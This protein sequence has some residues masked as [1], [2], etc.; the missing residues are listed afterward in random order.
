MP[1]RVGFILAMEEGKM[2]HDTWKEKV[3]AVM[4]LKGVRRMFGEV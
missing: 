3:H 1:G 2:K 4:R